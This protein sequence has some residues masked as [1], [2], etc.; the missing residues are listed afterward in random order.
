MICIRWASLVGFCFVV[1]C[2]KKGPEVVTFD[3]MQITIESNWEDATSSQGQR[4]LSGMP[5]DMADGT[6]LKK[7]WTR[8]TPLNAATTVLACLT[9]KLPEGV[10][11]E[12]AA[13]VKT[14]LALYK[15]DGTPAAEGAIDGIPVVWAEQAMKESGNTLQ[16]RVYQ[17]PKDGKLI[18]WIAGGTPES[19]SEYSPEIQRMIG[20]LKFVGEG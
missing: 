19:Y 11:S 8:G 13:F 15:R 12:P 14:M 3:G 4:F 9:M 17:F 18:M 1:G 2:A 20:S 5:P 6:E 16:I 7:Y 10:P